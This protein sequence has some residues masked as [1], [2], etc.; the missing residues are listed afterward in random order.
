MTTLLADLVD[1]AVATLILAVACC[2]GEWFLNHIGD[3]I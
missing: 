2:A 3:D 1:L